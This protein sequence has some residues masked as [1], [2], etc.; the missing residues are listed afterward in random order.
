MYKVVILEDDLSTAKELESFLNRYC[1]ERGIEVT[2]SHFTNA[3]DFLEAYDFKADVVFFDIEMPGM[4]GV[5]AAKK[6]REK[7]SRV[8]I[9]FATN[10]AQYAIE[11]YGVNALDFIL[12]PF[13]YPA[14][15][16][17]FG[18]IF[19]ELTHQHK[20]DTITVKNK[21]NV[22]MVAVNDIRYVEIRNHALVYHLTDGTIS[23]WGSLNSASETLSPYH[24]A[25]ANACYLVNLSH[26][27]GVSGNE[28]VVDEERLP[29]SK[30]KRKSF[31]GELAL[32]YGGS[33]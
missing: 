25:L 6:L 4:N 3:F 19:H 12:K 5:E 11:G 27:R 10:L 24:F 9:V 22:Q 2:T 28:V 18:R 26:V 23:T 1:K 32:Y 13:S 30:G 15:E 33:K 31:L 21:G 7:D 17:K 16:L 8:T 20:L 14:M 29:I